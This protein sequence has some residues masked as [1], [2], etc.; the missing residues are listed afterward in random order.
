MDQTPIQTACNKYLNQSIFFLVLYCTVSPSRQLLYL[1]HLSS[2]STL[3]AH[4]GWICLYKLSAAF[5]GTKVTIVPI[6]FNVCLNTI[7]LRLQ[8]TVVI[9]SLE[10]RSAKGKQAY[11]GSIF[12]KKKKKEDKKPT[13]CQ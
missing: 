2:L 5:T 13:Q 3:T 4:W 6:F 9:C 12:S 8:A 1:Q 7:I 11:V 10:V